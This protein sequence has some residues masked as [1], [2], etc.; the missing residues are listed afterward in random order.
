MR[1]L[2]SALERFAKVA[3]KEGIKTEPAKAASAPVPSTVV[4]EKRK[5]GRPR[6]EKPEEGIEEALGRAEGELTQ[7]NLDKLEASI[8][9]FPERSKVQPVQK[10]ASPAAPA[11]PP[12][13]KPTP[14]PAIPTAVAKLEI[15]KGSL[16]RLGP[17][18]VT[19][20]SRAIVSARPT[21]PPAAKPLGDIRTLDK[22]PHSEVKPFEERVARMTLNEIDNFLSLV[23]PTPWQFEVVK[24]ELEGRKAKMTQKKYADKPVI[25]ILLDAGEVP[26][27]LLKKEPAWATGS[28]EQINEGIKNVDVRLIRALSEYYNRL[29]KMGDLNENEKYAAKS[30]RDRIWDEEIGTA[31]VDE[32]PLL[33]EDM[34]K[35]RDMQVKLLDGSMVNPLDLSNRE[36]AEAIYVKT[37]GG[38]TFG[39]FKNGP[40]DTESK[41]RSPLIDDIKVRFEGSAYTLNNP[42]APV[43][44]IETPLASKALLKRLLF[45]KFVSIGEIKERKGKADILEAEVMAYMPPEYEGLKQYYRPDLK[46]MDMSDAKEQLFQMKPEE[47]HKTFQLYYIMKSKNLLD[48]KEEVLEQEMEELLK[49]FEEMNVISGISRP[50]TRPPP[51]VTDEDFK[52]YLEVVNGIFG[53]LPEE[54]VKGLMKRPDEEKLF[55]V[56]TTGIANEEEKKHFVNV[57]D[58][59]MVEALPVERMDEFFKTPE[60]KLYYKVFQKYGEI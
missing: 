55:W 51:K 33:P 50:R 59:L 56:L 8:K 37:G 47:L 21:P 1:E 29:E 9:A 38:A 54:A 2:V 7:E 60:G 11:A 27:N 35:L 39:D 57:M 18:S 42:A 36:L 48:K 26:H 28:Q 58:D 19:A 44:R 4:K 22:V 40:F 5:P 12:P 49:K 46:G 16:A 24:A 23:K 32:M 52:N 30:M 45:G 25:E 20:G 34:E 6:K 41:E 43:V 14:P 53:E 17:R 3:A 31:S 13:P 10:A 15:P